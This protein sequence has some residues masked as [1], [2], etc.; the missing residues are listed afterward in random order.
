MHEVDQDVVVMYIE[1]ADSEPNV[2]ETR[3]VLC[4]PR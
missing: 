4:K 2:S 3:A 1:V